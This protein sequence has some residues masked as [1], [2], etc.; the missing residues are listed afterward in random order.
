MVTVPVERTKR[1]RWL[2]AC[3][4]VTGVLLVVGASLV[5]SNDATP[6]Y[7]QQYARDVAQVD[8]LERTFAP[9][10]TTHPNQLGPVRA[11]SAALRRAVGLLST[12]SWPAGVQGEIDALVNSAKSNLR[13]LSSYEAQGP[14][15][16]GATIVAYYATA[17][18]ESQIGA[19]IRTALHLPGPPSSS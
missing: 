4:C 19:R 3:L 15:A 13:V 16:R 7:A 2:V 11:M 10:L 18:E 9:I 6:R 12:Q 1:R 5:V 14:G 8:S 17:R